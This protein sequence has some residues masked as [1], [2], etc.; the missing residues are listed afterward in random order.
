MAFGLNYFTIANQLAEGGFTGV[1]ILV[2]YVFGVSP[3]LVYLVLNIPL[4]IVGWRALGVRSMAYTVVGVLGVSGFL[5]LTQGLA[6][7]LPGDTLLA[8]LYAGVTVGAGLGIILR[9]G[10]TSGGADII[11]RL[12]ERNYGWSVG[13]T[14]FLFD[15][16]IIASSIPVIGRE[17]A[18]YTLV[19]VFLGGRV[20]DYV[21]E[22]SYG[23]KVAVIISNRA[24]QIAD[25]IHN[26]MERGTTFL[27]GTGGYTGKERPVL[28]CV[29]ARHEIYRLKEI[30]YRYD[31]HPFMVISDAEDVVGEGFTYQPKEQGTL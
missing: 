24:R 19:A 7:P 15:L 6:Q 14:L 30:V 28:Y 26:E 9:F 23:A 12:V 2:N 10:G 29:V 27:H 5:R 20:V 25:A 13:R 1:A 11:A 8:A 21:Q 18:L 4:F 3:G 16:V 17:R 22:V 31:D